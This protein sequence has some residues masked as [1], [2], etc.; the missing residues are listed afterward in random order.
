[1]ALPA[2]GRGAAHLQ[3]RASRAEVRLRGAGFEKESK[4][5]SESS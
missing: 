4:G 3:S 2:P 1:M 5:G